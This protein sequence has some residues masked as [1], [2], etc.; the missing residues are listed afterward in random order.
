[1]DLGKVI[2]RLETIE[3]HVERLKR[4]E[5]LLEKLVES[6]NRQAH[7]L[8]QMWQMYEQARKAQE[9]NTRM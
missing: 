7:Y 3:D 4:I 9:M 5:D 6:N 1:M 8:E 2:T